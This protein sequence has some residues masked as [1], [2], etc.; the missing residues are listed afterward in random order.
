MTSSYD[1][2][3]TETAQP[4]QCPQPNLDDE[5]ECGGN[6]PCA[7]HGQRTLELFRG[8]R[9]LCAGS[10]VDTTFIFRVVDLSPALD[11]PVLNEIRYPEIHTCMFV[12]VNTPRLNYSRADTI[13]D[14]TF[15]YVSPTFQYRLKCY[16]I[17]M[18]K[19]EIKKSKLL[20]TTF[21]MC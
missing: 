19:N 12:M 21:S 5:C 2:V 11:Q 17:A 10:Y 18:L 16:Y 20:V 6:H 4:T 9:V 1:P 15:I 13:L 8:R 7:Q 3:A 14:I